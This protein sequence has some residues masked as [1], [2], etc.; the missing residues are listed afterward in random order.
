MSEDYNHVKSLDQISE[1]QAR[2]INEII[3]TQ[4]FKTT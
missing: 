1:R 2:R 3:E 4:G